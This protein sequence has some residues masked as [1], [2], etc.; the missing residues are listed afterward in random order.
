[1][2]ETLHQARFLRLVRNGKWEY[3]ERTNVTGVVVIVAVTEARELLLVEQLR[4]AVGR[5]VVELPAGLAGDEP[6]ASG[7]ALS[8]AA[9]R[10]LLEETGYDAGSME[11]LSVGPSSAGL[12]SELLSI[13][14]AR[15]VKKVG[16][17]G[18]VPG[19]D[20]AVHV[21]PLARVPAFIAEREAAGAAVDAKVYAALYFAGVTGGEAL[22][23][24]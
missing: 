18:G 6:G 24:R 11:L 10:E 17:G 20:V 8:E 19:E 3:V 21:V 2:I 1:M 9:R 15:D 4:P 5:R 13:F 16:A 12:T 7:E 23:R 14:R 22:G